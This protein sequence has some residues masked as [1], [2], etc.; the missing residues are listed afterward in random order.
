MTRLTN[1]QLAAQL[2]QSNV[3]YETL[4]AANTSMEATIKALSAKMEQLIAS[5]APV[6]QVPAPIEQV[7]AIQ[8]SKVWTRLCGQ[9][10]GSGIFANESTGRV[11]TC[12][13]CSMPSSNHGVA[14]PNGKG[15]QTQADIERCDAYWDI[16]AQRAEA[17]RR[18]LNAR[19]FAVA[20]AQRAAK[21]TKP[22]A[23]EYE[24]EGEDS[25]EYDMSDVANWG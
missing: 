4:A 2:E 13:A 11:G 24:D 12:F 7:T 23:P 5:T 17:H 14:N 16:R 18:A 22:V 8:T 9:C 19:M 25:H 20:N 3:S 21:T 15:R 10:G 6:A 1:A